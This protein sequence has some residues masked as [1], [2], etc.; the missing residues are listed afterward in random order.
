MSVESPDSAIVVRYGKTYEDPPIVD[1]VLAVRTAL[2]MP[3]LSELPSPGITAAIVFPDRVKSG[4][5][6]LAHRRMSI[7]MIQ[8]RCSRRLTSAF[9]PRSRVT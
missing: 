8:G 3:P 5:H 6:P 1:A 9:F 7:P 4:A 2:D